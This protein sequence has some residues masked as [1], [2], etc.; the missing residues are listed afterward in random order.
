MYDVQDLVGI[1][2]K[3][4][5][6]F[7]YTAVVN[8]KTNQ[9]VHYHGITKLDTDIQ[10]S[11]ADQNIEGPN[12]ITLDLLTGKLYFYGVDRGTEVCIHENEVTLG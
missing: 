4:S 8:D 7:D 10:E 9:K 2:G 11:F 6:I 1:L 3:F 5:D 12:R